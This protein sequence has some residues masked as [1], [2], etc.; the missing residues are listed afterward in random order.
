MIFSKSKE[1]EGDRILILLYDFV[2]ALLNEGGKRDM[3][4]TKGSLTIYV[5]R[6]QVGRGSPNVYISR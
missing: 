1:I 2:R 5:D 4:F 3:N 6:R